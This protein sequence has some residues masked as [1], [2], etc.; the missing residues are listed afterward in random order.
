MK[1][2][3]H[4]LMTSAAALALSLSM[5]AHAYAQDAASEAAPAQDTTVI[6]T[7]IRKSLQSAL[8]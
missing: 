3:R 6:V 5:S 1:F 7:G 8:K 4:I 2:K